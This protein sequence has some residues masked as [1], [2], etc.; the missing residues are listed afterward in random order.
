[1]TQ[2]DSNYIDKEKLEL[3]AFEYMKY[4]KGEGGNPEP[5]GAMLLQ[6][7]DNIL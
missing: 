6:L 2:K 7:H 4:F 5:F 3:T 1:M